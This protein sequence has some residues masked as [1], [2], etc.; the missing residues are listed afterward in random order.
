MWLARKEIARAKGRFVM[1]SAA[2]GL[3]IF[4]ILFQ[5]ALLNGLITDF[6]GAVKNQNAEVLVFNEQARKNVEGSFLTPDQTAAIAT[7]DGVADTGLIGESTFTAIAGGV[8]TD[9]VLF[10]YELNGLGEPTTLTE[11]R[12]PQGPNEAIASAADAGDGFDIG[13]QIEIVGADGPVITVVGLGR[14]LRWSVSATLFVSYETFEAA[15]RAVNPDA[16]VVLPSLVAV[17][18]EAGVDAATVTERISASVPGTEALTR[19]QAI[20]ENPGVTGTRQSFQIILALGFIVV[21]IVVGF[22]FLILTVQKARPLTLLRAIGSP[23][24]FLVKNTLAQIALVWGVGVVIG[25]G[26]TFFALAVTPS[27]NLSVSVEPTAAAGSIAALF[28]LS[29]IAGLASVR[30]VLRIDPIDAT[31]D[32]SRSLQ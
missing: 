11:G 3:L 28:V 16:S 8:D 12:L 20:D 2:I 18:P 29:M 9:A 22:F 6:V 32:A 23:K 25:L 31:V 17:E 10:G 14:E 21:L 13:D 19:Q 4:L 1:L 24:S 30:R 5:Q 26:L 15:Q 7:V 27:G